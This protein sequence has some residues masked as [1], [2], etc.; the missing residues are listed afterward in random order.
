MPDSAR[1]PRV[2]KS[3]E[4]LTLIDRNQDLLPWR[5]A[6][7]LTRCFLYWIPVPIF[8]PTADQRT[9]ILTF[10][11]RLSQLVAAELGLREEVF[12]QFKALEDMKDVFLKRK[13]DF[14][15]MC[16]LSRRPQAPMPS[17]PSFEQVA[18]MSKEVLQTWKAPALDQFIPDYCYWFAKKSAKE[19]RELFF[20]RAG[21]TS[22]FLKPDGA[23]PAAQL[24]PQVGFIKK[25]PAMKQFDLE[26]MLQTAS[27]MQDPFLANSKKL[28]GPGLEHDP[29]FEGLLFI[30]P[31][32]ASAD[33]FG[34]P[35]EEAAKWFQL[36]DVYINES[37]AD[38]GVLM[39]FKVDFEEQIIDLVR[40][41]TKDG[42]VYQER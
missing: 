41:M 11:D 38:S 37:R 14:M 26:G 30:L 28:F 2:A 5:R 9:W 13:E 1:E 36:F 15:P 35:E 6:Q 3:T 24:P 27:A 17:F 8:P 10:I 4:R 12:L 29:Q 21:L 40:G 31:L 32:L 42:F 39:A 23:A 18:A 33:F 19:Q 7:N 34:Q 16:G 20:G 22:I 25:F